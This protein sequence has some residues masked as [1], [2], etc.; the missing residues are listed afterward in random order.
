MQRI[1]YIKESGLW[2]KGYGKNL[3]NESKLGKL[4]FVRK[5]FEI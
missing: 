5:L 3:K 4:I 2:Q 1:L